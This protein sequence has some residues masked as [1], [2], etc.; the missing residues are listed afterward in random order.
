MKFILERPEYINIVEVRQRS[1]SKIVLK[2]TVCTLVIY[3][4]ISCFTLL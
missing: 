4:A 3:A 1:I 2:T